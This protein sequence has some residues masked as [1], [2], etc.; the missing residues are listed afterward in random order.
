MA[1][2]GE[3]PRRITIIPLTEPAREPA[4]VPDKEEV[5]A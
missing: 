2:I 4:T 5:P 1:D 3:N